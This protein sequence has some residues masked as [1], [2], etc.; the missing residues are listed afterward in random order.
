M[1]INEQKERKRKKIHVNEHIE[2]LK[3]LTL[4]LGRQKIH[5]YIW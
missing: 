3:Y 5:H 2:K 1:T 4:Q